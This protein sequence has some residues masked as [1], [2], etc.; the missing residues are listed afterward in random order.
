MFNRIK[1]TVLFFA[2]KKTKTKQWDQDVEDIT[3]P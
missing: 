2:Q 3:V 1:G